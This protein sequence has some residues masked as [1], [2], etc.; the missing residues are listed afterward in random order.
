MPYDVLLTTTTNHIIDSD[1]SSIS[2][3]A[4]IVSRSLKKLNVHA[5]GGPDNVPPV[6]LNNCCNNLAYPIAYIFQL[7]FDNSFIPDVWRQAYI[8]PGFKKGDATQVCNYRPISLSCTLC[9]LM[10]SVIKDQLISRLVSKGLMN[11]HQHGFI[12]KHS[13]KTNLLEFTHDWSLAFHGKL[14]VDVIYIDFSKAFDSVV[15]SNLI[16][17]LQT[18]GI[19]RLLLKWIKAYFYMVVNSV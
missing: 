4:T 9:K 6:F 16:H 10:E 17:K 2:F 14:P 11:K 12:S 7:C 19:N 3:N 13:T 18:F 8:T 5:A 1:L 15:H